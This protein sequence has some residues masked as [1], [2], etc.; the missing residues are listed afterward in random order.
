MILW[1]MQRGFTQC[2]WVFST[3]SLTVSIQVESCFVRKK[4]NCLLSKPLRVKNP[5]SG[6]QTYCET[7]SHQNAVNCTERISKCW[8]CL[9][10]GGS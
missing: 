9:S 3:P 6:L 8:K 1:Q 4:R 10:R 2:I 7:G 5:C